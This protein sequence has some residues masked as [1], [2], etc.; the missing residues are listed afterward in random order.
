[1]LH[2]HWIIQQKLDLGVDPLFNNAYLFDATVN[3]V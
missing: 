2:N 3:N 1:M